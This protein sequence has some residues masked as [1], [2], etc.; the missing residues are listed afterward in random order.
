[1]ARAVAVGLAAVAALSG[2]ADTPP[3]GAPMPTSST[4]DPN[5][6]PV[7]LP[8]YD[9]PDAAR[10]AIRTMLLD[11]AAALIRA[12]E[13]PLGASAF[14]IDNDPQR[15]GRAGVLS[16]AER[17]TRTEPVSRLRPEQW[18]RIEGDMAAAARDLGW[19]QAGEYPG[20][21]LRKGPLFFRGGCSIHS[22]SYEMET[23]WTS[24]NVQ[25]YPFGEVDPPELEPLKRP[26]P[27]PAPSP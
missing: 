10:A 20:L 3:K 1:M 18:P 7:P 11:E 13:F 25:E 24:Q 16:F 17:N 6:D 9:N 12:S 21:N 23:S 5:A 19:T 26:L 15:G 22:C 14:S 2:C 27:S 4:P 8:T